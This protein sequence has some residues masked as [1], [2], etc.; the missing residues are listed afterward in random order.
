MGASALA[1]HGHAIR[2]GHQGLDPCHG[3]HTRVKP[4]ATICRLSLNRLAM[5]DNLQV[6]AARPCFALIQHSSRDRARDSV[7]DI[8]VVVECLT[9]PL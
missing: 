4:P 5:T 7:V 1:P 3:H 8:D 2:A 6:G 9:I